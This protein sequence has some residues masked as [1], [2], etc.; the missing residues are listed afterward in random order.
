M[1]LHLKNKTVVITGGSTGIGLAAS[2]EFAREGA[3]VV[4]CGRSEDKLANAKAAF[5]YEHLTVETFAGDMSQKADVL[6]LAEHAAKLYGKI[7]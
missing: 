1:D 6:A 7:D 3:N 5:E 4:V 2:L